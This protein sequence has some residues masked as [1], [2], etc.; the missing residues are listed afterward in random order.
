MLGSSFPPSVGLAPEG[1][2]EA[3]DPQAA[4]AKVAVSASAARR[5]GL[6]VVTR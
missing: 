2:G 1:L 3:P 5:L 4:K 6:V